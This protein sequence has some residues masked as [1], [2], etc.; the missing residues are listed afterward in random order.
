MLSNLLSEEYYPEKLRDFL[1]AL[2]L[3]GTDYHS[4]Q[5][6]RGYWLQCLA[7]NYLYVWFGICC[8]ED[9]RRVGDAERMYRDLVE[10]YA[11]RM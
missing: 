3:F 10:R 9:F 6:S 8:P 2:A 4:G 7:R 1:V 5:R 11:D